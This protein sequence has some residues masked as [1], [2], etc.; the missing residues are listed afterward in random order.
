MDKPMPT[1]TEIY[2]EKQTLF[3]TIENR[4]YFNVLSKISTR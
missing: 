3:D 4:H 2:A 1:M